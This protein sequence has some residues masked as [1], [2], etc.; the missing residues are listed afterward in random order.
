MAL[1]LLASDFAG[2]T[3][4]IW[5]VTP[6]TLAA[7]LDELGGPVAAFARACGFEASAGALQ[8]VPDAAGGIAGALFGLGRHDDALADGFDP[9]F[10][11]AFSSADDT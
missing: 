10:R 8:V 3:L 1:P 5:T 9:L 6:D 7:R 11:N 2:P 4:P